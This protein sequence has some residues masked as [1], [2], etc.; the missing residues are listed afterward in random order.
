M[1]GERSHREQAS[2]DRHRTMPPSLAV[3]QRTRLFAYSLADTGEDVFLALTKKAKEMAKIS[4]VEWETGT[5][6]L[7]CVVLPSSLPR[8]IGGSKLTSDRVDRI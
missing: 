6:G 7:R 8:A 2:V 5:Q 3:P 4:R 1:I